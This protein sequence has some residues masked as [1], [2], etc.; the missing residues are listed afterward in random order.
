VVAVVTGAVLVSGTGSDVGKSVVVQGLCR[1]LRRRGVRVAPFKAQNMS[2]NSFVTD[3]GAEIARAQAAQA[4]AA[5]IPPDAAMN[6]VLLKPVDDR[7]AQVIVMGR[8]FCESD[9]E[10]YLDLRPR[11]A[12]IV[13]NAF[14]DL[15][16][17]FDVV[18]CEGAGSLAEINLRDGDLPNLGL[19]RAAEIPVVI[20]ADIDKGGVFA[21]LYGSVALLDAG[22]RSLVAGFII[23]KFRGQYSILDPGLAMIANLTG[24]PVL[25]V[26][27]WIRD[28]WVD[29]EDAV[30]LR[31]I[32]GAVRPPLGSDTLDVAVL[33]LR[34]MSNVTDV[35]PI[36][37]EPGVSVRFTR[38]FADLARADLVIVPG[39]KATVEDL[40]ELRA[41]G[42]DRA[43]A[44]RVRRGG[45]VLG[46]CG[47]YQMLGDRIVDAYESRRG[48]VAGL[49][50]LPVETTFEPDKILGRP[51]GIAAAFGGAPTG[52]YEIHNGRVRRTGGDPMFVTH[53]G[54]EGCRTG[55]V[56]GTSWHGVFES[57]GFRAA[58]LA[59]VAAERRLDWHPGTTRFADVRERTFDTIADA[60]ERHLD[61]EALLA[62]IERGAVPLRRVRR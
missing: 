58:F 19:A 52:G 13:R 56:L 5:R 7:R 36:A 14:E 60:I 20:V 35:D 29:A 8:A 39:S 9:A 6:P 48:E 46:I 61:T 62:V 47:G 30:P 54:D 18:V 12:G 1:W 50:L 37:C 38:S 22:D 42:L 2:L 33:A 53:D 59:W 44:A 57:D 31:S 10:E 25:G 34:H 45:P 55:S 4:A 40:N 49:G 3:G 41:D 23:N 17:R 28:L 21:S 27:P 32:A 26:L 24:L 15:R 51:R 16:A 43:L 11:L